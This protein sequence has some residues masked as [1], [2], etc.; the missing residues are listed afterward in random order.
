MIETDI[1]I[2]I[3]T[4]DRSSLVEFIADSVM[5]NIAVAGKVE[6]YEQIAAEV[7][8]EILRRFN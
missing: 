2:T 5:Y 3:K 8:E 7:S 6:N 4:W 1:D